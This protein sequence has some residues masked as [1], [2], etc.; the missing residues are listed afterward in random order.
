MLTTG[1]VTTQALQHSRQQ[2]RRDSRMV[3][4]QRIHHLHH[5]AARIVS[6]KLPRIENVISHER[7]RNDLS[8]SRP[9]HRMSDRTTTT[10]ARSQARARRCRRH[11]RWQI[12]DALESENFFHQVGS[13]S[14]IRAPGRRRDGENTRTIAAFAVRLSDIAAN[15]FQTATR[16]PGW[17]VHTGD[18]AGA[19]SSDLDGFHG[20]NIAHNAAAGL[21]GAASN[22]GQQ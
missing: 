20:G 7:S 18:N 14:Q 3:R 8:E 1:E 2:R 9:S 17:V 19:I 21:N 6:R 15:F 4:L 22:L 11:D 12:L 16:R 5:V 10:L 13:H